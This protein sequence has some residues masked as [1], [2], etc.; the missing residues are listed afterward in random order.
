MKNKGL[1]YAIGIPLAAIGFVISLLSLFG[2][3]VSLKYE[4]SDPS[5]CY[6]TI[7]HRNLCLIE[8]VSIIGVFTFLGIMVL[9]IVLYLLTL[10]EKKKQLENEHLL[11]DS[12]K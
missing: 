8:T 9:L 10:N 12:T 6:S 7:D 1:Y 2:N 11:D 4:T 5:D 3:A